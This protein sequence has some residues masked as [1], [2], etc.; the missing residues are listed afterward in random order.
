MGWAGGSR[1][2]DELWD[3]V[4]KILTKGQRRDVARQWIDIFEG[5]DCDTMDETELID[6]AGLRYD[7]DTGER[8][9]K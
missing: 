3:T 8:V 6:A 5:E 2:A 9:E 7:E 4:K 1:L